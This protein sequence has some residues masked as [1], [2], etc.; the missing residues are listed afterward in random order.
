MHKQKVNSNLWVK[1]IQKDSMSLGF[2]VDKV[3][4]AGQSE[5][6]NVDVVQTRDHGKMLLNDGL[7]MLCERDEFIYHDMITHVP[8]FVHPNPKKVLIVG[9]GD[10]GTARE[11]LRHKSV[12]LCKMVEIDKMVVD[13]C[14]EHIP[15]TAKVMTSKDPRFQLVIEDAVKYVAETDQMYD[16]ILVDSTDPIGPAT[17]LFGSQFYKDIFSKLGPEG[18]VISQGESPFYTPEMQKTMFNI[19][20]EFFP[21][22]TCYNFSNMTYP[23]SLWSFTFASKKYHPIRDFD[24]QKVKD[25]GL[26]FKYYNEALHAASFVLP[27]FMEDNL[28]GL[29]KDN[30]EL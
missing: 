26:S 16:V 6:Q 2:R 25:S 19:L 27:Q 10:G 9:G 4:F 8:L 21:I 5:F 1:E 23:G 30:H 20:G 14:V 15:Q 17:P 24:P 28:K 22:V 3:L 18:M 13:A 7:I 12:E 11:V 29:K